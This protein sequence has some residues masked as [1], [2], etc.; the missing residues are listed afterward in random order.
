MMPRATESAVSLI[1]TPGDLAHT[2]HDIGPANLAAKSALGQSVLFL[3]DCPP[4][5]AEG[6]AEPQSYCEK[7]RSTVTEP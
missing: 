5:N 6:E 1:P 3:Y 2:I 4:S 7:P